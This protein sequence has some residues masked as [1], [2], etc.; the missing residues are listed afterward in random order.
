MN[1]KDR[2]DWLDKILGR[3]IQWI[4]AADSRIIILLGIDTAMLGVLATRVQILKAWTIPDACAVTLALVALAISLF[5]VG[6][7]AVPRTSGPKQSLI[8]F[9]GIADH[10]IEQFK[11]AMENLT[12]A[13]LIKDLANQTHRNAQIASLKF[14]WVT[15]S[16]R[17]LVIAITPWAVALF[18]MYQQHP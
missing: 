18:L 7:A 3:Q 12:N 10:D 11:T 1:E 8:F 6:M 16:L 2:I 15:C 14:R 4:A 13:D 5:S 17:L 9:Q